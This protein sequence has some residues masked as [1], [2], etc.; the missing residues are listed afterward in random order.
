MFSRGVGRGVGVGVG[1]GGGGVL[2]CTYLI[3]CYL[4]C[5]DA[6]RR[7]C[8]IVECDDGDVTLLLQI[9]RESA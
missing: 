6:F 4:H 7:Y 9:S 8:Y 5:K 1:G 2:M 3:L